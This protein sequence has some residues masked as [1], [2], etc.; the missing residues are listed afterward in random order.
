M[1][2][3]SHSALKSFNHTPNTWILQGKNY[4]RAG[5]LVN[6]VLYYVTVGQQTIQ[7]LLDME[8][9]VR[10]QDILGMDIQRYVVM[11]FCIGLFR[12]GLTAVSSVRPSN[13]KK[14]KMCSLR[15]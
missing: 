4:L 13:G 9:Y 3:S 8:A 12:L 15:A 10:L 14:W 11:G 6:S 7:A 2:L 1:S 5:Y